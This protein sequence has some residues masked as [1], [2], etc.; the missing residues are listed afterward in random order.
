MKNNKYIQMVK[1]L[2]SIPLFFGVSALVA[3]YL[4]KFDIVGP[5][6]SNGKPIFSHYSHFVSYGLLALIGISLIYCLFQALKVKGWQKYALI[7]FIVLL[8]PVQYI[9]VIAMQVSIFGK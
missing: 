3:S 1:S 8:L 5:V 4:K 7:T 9:W 6:G 2:M